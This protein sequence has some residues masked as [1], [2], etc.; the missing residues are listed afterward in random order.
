[1]KASRKMRFVLPAAV[2]LILVASLYSRMNA[3]AKPTPCSGE[4]YDDRNDLP[5]PT[6]APTKRPPRDV[7]V[8]PVPGSD[9]TASR[10]G[11]IEVEESEDAYFAQRSDKV[12]GSARLSG[13]R[14]DGVADRLYDLS[15]TYLLV[16]GIFGK[17]TQADFRA[18]CD[19]THL[20]LLVEVFDNTRHTAGDV[21]TRKD[22]V[23]IFIN[24]SGLRPG[25]YG[26]G[27]C[28]FIFL[29]DGTCVCGNGADGDNAE[30]VVVETEGGYRMEIAIRFVLP[31]NRRS[32]DIGFDIRVNDAYTAENRDAITAWSDTSLLTHKDLR[33]VGILSLR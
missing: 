12:A 29:R 9:I 30:F 18:C 8:T 22:G 31:S 33:G 17:P 23:E 2:L 15:Q 4:R 10:Y 3:N 14:I 26:E 19:N 21:P 1:M 16:N 6:P 13:I 27:D 24:E 32:N 7:T 20:Y 5:T 25:Q 11:R 28:H